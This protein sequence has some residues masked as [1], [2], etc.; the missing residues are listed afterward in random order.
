MDYSRLDRCQSGS[1]AIELTNSAIPVVLVN[2]EL[3]RDGIFDSP[4][5]F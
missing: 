5:N 3:K 2:V 1:M 4:P